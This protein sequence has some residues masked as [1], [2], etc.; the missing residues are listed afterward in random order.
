MFEGEFQEAQIEKDQMEEEN[1]EELE[2]VL[3]EDLEDYP[4]LDQICREFEV[5]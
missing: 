2:T 1:R 4:I 5:I 3:R